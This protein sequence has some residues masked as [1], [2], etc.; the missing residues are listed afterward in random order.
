[1]DLKPIF[2]PKEGINQ[3]NYYWFEKGFSTQEVETIVSGSLEY[4][5]QKAIIVDE[6][7]TDR[8]RKSNIK[9]LPYD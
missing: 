9:W 5:F 8:F 4:E 6:N 1:M 3:T 7:N 2:P